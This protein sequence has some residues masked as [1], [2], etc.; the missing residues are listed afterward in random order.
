MLVAE[1]GHVARLQDT[2]R[3]QEAGSQFEVMPGRAHDHAHRLAPHADLERLLGRKLVIGGNSTGVIC[4]AQYSG[5]HLSSPLFQHPWLRFY[6]AR[7]LGALEHAGNA[8]LY[9]N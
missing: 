1:Q 3:E 9:G 6:R 8:G 5:R 2:F 4:A 7:K